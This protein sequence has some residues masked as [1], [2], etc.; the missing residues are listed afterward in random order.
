MND[1]Q[2]AG[3]VALVTGI[4]RGIGRAIVLRYAA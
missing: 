2:L 3:K 4:S 1:P